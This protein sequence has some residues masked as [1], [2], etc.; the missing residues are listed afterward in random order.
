[1][2]WHHQHLQGSCRAP[3]RPWGPS[4]PPKCGFRRAVWD[5]AQDEAGTVFIVQ[6]NT[7]P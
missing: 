4:S 7:Q 3:D 2:G 5:S 1:M 6:F